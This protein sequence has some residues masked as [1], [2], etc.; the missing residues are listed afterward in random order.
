ME[1][2]YSIMKKHN[3]QAFSVDSEKCL[4][5]DCGG[6]VICYIGKEGENYSHIIK[7]CEE[8]FNNKSLEPD[9]DDFTLF[10]M[11]RASNIPNKGV[12]RLGIDY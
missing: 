2:L 5:Q 9:D 6:Y 12:Y 7:E 1:N 4:N 3:V 11:R 8:L 10:I